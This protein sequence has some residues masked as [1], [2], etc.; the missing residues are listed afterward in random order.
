[1]VPMG[2]RGAMGL[3]PHDKW[4]VPLCWECHNRQHMTGETTFWTLQGINPL[5]LAKALWWN[6]GN[7]SA[8]HGIVMRARMGV[9]L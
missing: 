7:E 6:S 4:S 3:K 9:T 2:E 5:E 8:G 1:M